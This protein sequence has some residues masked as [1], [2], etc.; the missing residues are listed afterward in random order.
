ME[1]EKDPLREIGET[2][3]ERESDIAPER[4]KEE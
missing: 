3:P 4:R 1:E 2:K